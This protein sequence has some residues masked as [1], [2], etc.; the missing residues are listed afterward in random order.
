MLHRH[1][2]VVDLTLFRHFNDLLHRSIRVSVFKVKKDGIVEKNSVLWDDTY[3][4]TEALNFQPF[5]VL[6][7]NSNFPRHRI[8]DAE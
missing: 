5:Q 3:V 2:S 1:D 4:L 6:P 7:I 8:I